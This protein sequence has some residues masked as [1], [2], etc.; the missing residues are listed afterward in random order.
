MIFRLPMS[1]RIVRCVA[2]CAVAFAKF[3]VHADSIPDGWRMP[4]HWQVGIELSGGSVPATNNFLR[5][6][7]S[8]SRIVDATFSGSVRCDFSF[9][10]DSRQ[11]ILYRG[12]YQG[13]GLGYRSFCA[14]SLL[15][16]PI[17][18]F[19]YQGAPVFRFSR[20][21]WLGYEWRF[22][23]A[24]GWKY[25]HVEPDGYYLEDSNMNAVVS[26]PVTAY[27]GIALKLHYM[28][29]PRWEVSA[30]A[31]GMH[32]SNGN[33]SWPNAGVNAIGAVLGIS[34][35]FDH[36]ESVPAKDAA[37]LEAEADR[38]RWML[39]MMAYGAWRKRQVLADDQGQLCPGRFGVVGLQVAPM[40]S[41]NR[42]VAAG[43]ALD[44]Q[45]DES[46]GLAPYWVEGTSGDEI[47]FYRPPFGKQLSLGISAHAELTMPIFSV[48]VGVGYD[49]L[50]PLGNQRF[51]QS[52]SLKTF[53]TRK[54]FLNVGYRLGD[55]KYPQ[56][57][58]LG[59]GIRL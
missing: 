31:E 14:S 49:M 50:S 6:M 42:W 16:T 36:A 39:D 35:M 38:Q 5:G 21:L 48:N 56:N 20:K 29:S 53:V 47:K 51:Y 43:L 3:S 23:A 46:A 9:D 2:V 54:L 10:P 15:G 55:F 11:G 22:G 40:R 34:Y 58:M 26:T 52:L 45:Y 7:N 1:N 18:A 32:F 19:I 25:C 17:T 33:T 13:L 24:F 57:L 28:L 41:F 59:A 27:M 8:E 44:M 12:A 37:S 4:L 30:G